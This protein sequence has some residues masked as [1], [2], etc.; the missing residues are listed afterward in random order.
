MNRKPATAAAPSRAITKEDVARAAGVS[1]IT[2]SRVINTPEKVA[3]ATRERVE[4]FISSM[5]Y[6]PNMLAGGLASRRTR[7]V[8]AIVPTISHSIFAETVRGLSEQLSLQGYQLLLGQTNYS[9]EAETGLVEAFIGRRV[10]GLVLTGVQHSV[11]TRQRLKAAGIPVVETWDLTAQ[12]IDM[13]VGFDNHAAGHAMGQYLQRKGYRRMAFV[14]G[15]DPRGLARYAGMREA[16]LA[17]SAPEPVHLVMP[18]GSFLQAGREAICRLLALQPGI[19]AAFFSNDVLAAGAALECARR[20]IA[21]PQRIALAGFA[22]LDIA[23]EVLPA[24]TTV[25][26]SAHQ[27]GLTAAEMLLTRFDGDAVTQTVC[28]LGYAILERDSA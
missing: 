2:V 22:N 3:P 28:D 1:H 26:I 17:Q 7:I 14:G 19:D 23:P 12:P 6:I 8:A 18:M 4:A 20:G 15:E 13:L 5:G 16:L 27:I 11:R 24:L 10:D 25:Q 9:E 21:V